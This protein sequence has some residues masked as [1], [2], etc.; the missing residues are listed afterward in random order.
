MKIFK[1]KLVV[2]V[3][4]LQFIYSMPVVVHQVLLLVVQAGWYTLGIVA[5]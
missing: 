3:G 5:G 1:Y 4:C 2:L